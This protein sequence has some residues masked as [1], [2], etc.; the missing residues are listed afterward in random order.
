MKTSSERRSAGRISAIVLWLSAAIL[1]HALFNRFDWH[2]NTDL[3]W[4]KSGY[5]L[6]LPATFIYHDLDGYAFYP[7]MNGK[8]RFAPGADFWALHPQE[9]TGRLL[10]KYPVGVAVFHAPFF[11]A[12]HAITK[13]FT[14]YPADG[15]STVYR[16]FIC[17]S[18]AFWTICAL[19]LLRSMLRRY[20]SDGVVA[21]TVAL[22]LFGTNLLNYSAFDFGMSHP[23]SF[24]LYAAALYLADR[25]HVNGRSKSL[26]LLGLVA[27][28]IFIVRP[29]NLLLFPFLLAWQ[30]AAGKLTNPF[31]RFWRQRS[32][33]I[34]AVVVFLAVVALQFS[35]WK[36]ATGDWLHYS[37]EGEVFVFSDPQIF[38]GLFSYRKG[39]FVYTPLALFAFLGLIPMFRERRGLAIATLLYFAVTIYFIFSWGQW[40]YGGSF[41]CRAMIESLA[42]LSFPLAYFIE[43]L[44]KSVVPIRVAGLTVL[45][46]C[47]VLNVW[48]TYQFSLRIIPTDNNTRGWYW[49]A[50]FKLHKTA[51]DDEFLKNDQS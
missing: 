9:K 11:F 17:I 12:A 32:A 30:P 23:F 1:T 36:Y 26:M 24:F 39:W 48:Q 15:Y 41:G 18:T 19:W 31:P 27:G 6:Y 43:W 44:R 28:M 7:E 22:L 45:A 35:Y 3:H 42:V 50:F 38:N 2:S 40:F 4:D 10:N 8:Y 33:T 34:L 37:Y 21:M 51:E 20:F 14:D 25:W 5:Y 13:A 47:I 46:L 49:R 16:L 29:L